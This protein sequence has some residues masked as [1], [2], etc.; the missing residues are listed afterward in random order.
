MFPVS[1]SRRCAASSSSHS[2]PRSVRYRPTRS[3]TSALL[4]RRARDRAELE[5]EVEHRRAQLRL[6]HATD[7]R[8]RRPGMREGRSAID[9]DPWLDFSPPPADLDRRRLRGLRDRANHVDRV[10][11]DTRP[12]TYDELVARLPPFDVPASERSTRIDGGFRAAFQPLRARRGRCLRG[13]LHEGEHQVS[14][15]PQRVP[16]RAAS[17]RVHDPAPRRQRVLRELRPADVVHDVPHVPAFPTGAK[18][19]DRIA[20]HARQLDGWTAVGGT[21]F[22]RQSYTR[23]E[24]LDRRRPRVPALDR[25]RSS[26]W[27]RSLIHLRCR[28]VPTVRSTP[29]RKSTTSFPSRPRTRSCPARH[30][31]A[32]LVAAS[33]RSSSRPRPASARSN[34]LLRVGSGSY[35]QQ[36]VV[37]WSF[38]QILG[39]CPPASLRVTLMSLRKKAS[40]PSR[41][42]VEAERSGTYRMSGPR[43]ASRRLRPARDHGGVDGASSR[44]VAVPISH[45]A[46]LFAMETVSAR[47][48]TTAARSP[49]PSRHEARRD[50]HPRARSGGRRAFQNSGILRLACGAASR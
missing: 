41:C 38:E 12:T 22:E 25:S 29:S 10:G 14:R 6:L 32:R 11:F 16:R 34:E 40:H 8:R 9:P 1:P 27:P 43:H 36:I 30:A 13:D 24:A 49:R 15:Q 26:R 37:E 31:S 2:R 42:R 46:S 44:S 45:L 18:P 17:H 47:A 48:R 23:G 21:P 19:A 35:P 20:F 39:D 7:P 5:E 4:P 28:R 33:R 50:G 3:A